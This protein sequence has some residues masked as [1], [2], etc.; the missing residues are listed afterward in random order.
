MG[1]ESD[2]DTAS[3]EQRSRGATRD[4]QLYWL[5]D[6]LPPLIADNDA[7]I[8]AVQTGQPRGPQTGIPALD[9]SLGGYLAPGLHL[10]QARRR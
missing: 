10:L 1:K 7:A 9:K 8:A 3:A 5:A 4:A 2:N 6:L